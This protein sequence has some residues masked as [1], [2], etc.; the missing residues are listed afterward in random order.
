[1]SQVHY[2]EHDEVKAIKMGHS[3]WGKPFF[4]V[5]VYWLDGLLI[6]SGQR[7][8]Q[9]HILHF[10][11]ELNIEQIA[12]THHHEDHSGNI[13]ALQTQHPQVP[14]WAGNETRSL[15]KTGFKIKN[16][17]K[18]VF[19]NM[20]PTDGLQPLPPE[21]RTS[22]Y[23]LTPIFTPGHASDHYSFLE[24]SKG[25]LFSGDL[26]LGKIKFTR[27]DEHV[28]Q[29]IQSIKTVLRYD[30][31][32]LFCAHHPRLKDG[33]KHMQ[34]KLQYLEELTGKVKQ[35]YA[36]GH[37]IQKI[38]SLLGRKEVRFAKLYTSNDVGVDYMIRSI[39]EDEADLDAM[40]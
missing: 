1:M 35:L 14:I 34:A 4:F 2:F 24:K 18:F 32:T 16:Y 5:H 19:G 38:I 36:Q 31:D 10:A 11:Q 13:K 12:L 22:Q 21:I 37:H 17:Q 30:F 25:W 3:Y 33:K 23:T 7:K 39:L 27:Q 9:K 15:V 8:M 20:I 29:M 40:S 6:D 28:P 26:Y